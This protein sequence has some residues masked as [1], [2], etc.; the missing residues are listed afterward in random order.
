MVELRLWPGTD[1]A[2]EYGL[3]DVLV[4]PATVIMVAPQTDVNATSRVFTVAQRVSPLASFIV[5][6][7]RDEVAAKL[8][9][10][11]GSRE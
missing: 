6:G 3:R 8:F 4:N 5:M 1:L 2:L 7:S 11:S 10:S 9:P